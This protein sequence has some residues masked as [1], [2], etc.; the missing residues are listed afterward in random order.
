MAKDKI[1]DEERDTIIRAIPELRELVE[2]WNYLSWWQK[3][4]I[5]LF[6]WWHA[7]KNKM[8]KRAQ[9]VLWLATAP[10]RLLENL[11]DKLAA[12]FVK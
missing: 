12:R 4:D 1:S 11:L 3:R 10:H 7:E 5:F 2:I 6:V 9:R 8:I